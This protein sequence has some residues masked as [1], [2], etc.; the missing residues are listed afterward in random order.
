VMLCRFA[1]IWLANPPSWPRAGLGLMGLLAALPVY[2]LGFRRLARQNIE[3]IKQLNDRAC[4]FSFLAWRSY[5]VVAVMIAG[6]VLLRHSAIPKHWL[7]VLY[8]AIGGGL[9]LASF[10]YYGHLHRLAGNRLGGRR[11]NG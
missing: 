9:F 11:G 3:R 8:G 5:A 6:G 10:V 2:R 1:Y 7:A 4:L